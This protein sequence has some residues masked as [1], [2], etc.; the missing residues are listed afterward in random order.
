MTCYPTHF[1]LA[2]PHNTPAWFTFDP[3]HA[4]AKQLVLSVCRS[5]VSQSVSQSVSRLSSPKKIK[6]SRHIDPHK[7]S[8]GSQTTANS[9]K[10]NLLYV[11]LTEVKGASFRCISTFHNYIVFITLAPPLRDLRVPPRHS[12]PETPGLVHVKYEVN[13]HHPPPCPSIPG[14]QVSPPIPGCTKDGSPLVQ[15]SPPIPGC[16]KDG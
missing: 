4:C 2:C 9:K 6:K 1:H 14:F 15:V 8:K 10:K 12:C 7:P 3:A 11:Y 13:A 16:T 5:V